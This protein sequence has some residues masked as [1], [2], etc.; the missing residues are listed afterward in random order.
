[1]F[2]KICT[3]EQEKVIFE[4]NM[5]DMAISWHILLT[6]YVYNDDYESFDS[7]RVKAFSKAV[8][9]FFKGYKGLENLK[10]KVSATGEILPVGLLNYFAL[11]SFETRM[12]FEFDYFFQFNTELIIVRYFR[13]YFER[14]GRPLSE[15]DTDKKLIEEFFGWRFK[16]KSD[17]LRAELEEFRKE[18]RE[19][20]DKRLRKFKK[21]RKRKANI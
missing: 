18:I 11:A 21:G 9:A 12:H 17:N 16:A 20:V 15:E 4:H 6:K 14:I 5:L 3:P 2:H 8:N 7:K 13:E 19:G 10:V 1:M